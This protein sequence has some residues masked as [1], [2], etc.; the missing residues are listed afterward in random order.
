MLWGSES[1]AVKT[2]NYVELTELMLNR[3][4]VIDSS[5][6]SNLLLCKEAVHIKRRKPQLNNGLKASRELLS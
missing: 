6:N 3:T 4:K 5:N 2:N 1:I